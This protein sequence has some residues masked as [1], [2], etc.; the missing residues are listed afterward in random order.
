LAGFRQRAFHAWFRFHRPMTLG[1]RAIVENARGEVMLVEHTYVEGWHLP[2]GG[3]ETGE[4]AETALRRE[5]AEE[6]GLQACGRAQLIGI[7]ANHANFPNDHVLLYRL[8]A[9]D[10]LAC[11]PDCE[12]EI[13]AWQWADPARPPDGTTP[14]TRKRLEEF[15]GGLPPAPTW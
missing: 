15:L 1:V 11:A 3:V 13:A 4:T 5:I 7:Y 10:W 2:G 12:G 9:A 6:A 14:A 8:R